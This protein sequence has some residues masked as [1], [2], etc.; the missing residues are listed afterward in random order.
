MRPTSGDFPLSTDRS[1]PS[2]EDLFEQGILKVPPGSSV[3]ARVAASQ[4]QLQRR[5]RASWSTRPRLSNHDSTAPTSLPGRSGGSGCSSC[6]QITATA[7]SK[8]AVASTP[9][10]SRAQDA[11]PWPSATRLSDDLAHSLAKRPSVEDLRSTGIMKDNVSPKLAE[12][13]AELKKRRLSDELGSRLDNRP[14]L[15]MLLERGYY[16]AD[17]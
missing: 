11:G 9:P 10:R 6:S 3:S 15:D 7:A 2:A 12:T 1:R 4:E 5:L 14:S 16:F 8:L 13:T 17:Q